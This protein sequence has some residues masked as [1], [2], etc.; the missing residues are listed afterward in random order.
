MR[1]FF[2]IHT[3]FA[4]RDERQLLCGAVGHDGHV[5]LFVDVGAIFNVQAADLLAF[6]ACLMRLELHAQNVTGQALD[7]VNGLGNLDAAALAAATG[8]N[9]RL[10]D[11]DGAAELLSG[12]HRLLNCKSR[13]AAGYWHTEL[14][15]NFFALVFVDFH[16]VSF[17]AG[18]CSSVCNIN[19]PQS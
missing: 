18:E 11:P 17:G 19:L 2:N 7:I 9:L 4:G 14:A 12:F 16:D 5:V 6:W 8:V 15:Q 3:A 13:D 1:H 10:H